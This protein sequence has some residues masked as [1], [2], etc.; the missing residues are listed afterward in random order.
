MSVIWRKTMKVSEA[1][2]LSSRLASV[3]KDLDSVKKRTHI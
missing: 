3:M 1:R 2:G